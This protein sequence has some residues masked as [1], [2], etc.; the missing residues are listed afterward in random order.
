MGREVEVQA[1]AV[2]CCRRVARD[3][4]LAAVGQLIVGQLRGRDLVEMLGAGQDRPVGEPLGARSAELA[5]RCRT[6]IGALDPGLRSLAEPALARLGEQA[7]Y[8]RLGL[9]VG[10]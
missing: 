4:P 1:G 2:A 3:G 9:R 5:L 8:P 6:G 7:A 10:A